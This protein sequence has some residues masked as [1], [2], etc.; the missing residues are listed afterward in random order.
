MNERFGCAR[1]FFSDNRKS[2]IENLKLVGLFALVLT[3]AFGG[4]V[5]LRRSSRR[6][7]RG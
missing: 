3:F 2:K 7:S 6:K 5:A 1:E 4:A